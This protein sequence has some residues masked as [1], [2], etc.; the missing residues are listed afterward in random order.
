MAGCESTIMEAGMSAAADHA[1]DI[2]RRKI[3]EGAFSAGQRLKESE[4]SEICEVSRTPVRE[5]LRRLVAD[6]LV[7]I[8]PNSGA[9]VSEWDDRDIVDIYLVRIQLESLAAGLAAQR[10]TEAQLR[11]M[12]A[13]ARNMSGL[14][15]EGPGHDTE[16]EIAKLNNEFHHLII[17]AAN[18]RALTAAA[19][20]VVEAPLMLRTFRIYDADRLRRSASDHVELVAAIAAQDSDSAESLMRA[21]ILSGLRMLR[22][23][24]NG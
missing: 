2:I 19:A 20:Q 13:L 21:H 23:A 22:E 14:V 17:T 18:S 4:L 24:Q 1:Y 5:A 15:S 11:Q 7:I 9:I 10:R 8:T 3:L 12:D 16:I 6:G